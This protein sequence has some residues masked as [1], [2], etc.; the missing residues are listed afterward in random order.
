MPIGR[1]KFRWA[2]TIKHTLPLYPLQTK[3]PTLV[4]SGQVFWG[5]TKKFL[6]SNILLT[7]RVGYVQRQ[8]GYTTIRLSSYVNAVSCKSVLRS[9]FSLSTSSVYNWVS[10]E[11]S[12]AFTVSW[13]TSNINRKI[14]IFYG[15]GRRSLT[16][17]HTQVIILNEASYKHQ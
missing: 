14:W 12:P 2:H 7:T 15:P 3:V 13:H 6:N 10:G 8:T 17:I 1:L 4:V 5:F 16:I 11:K 9:M